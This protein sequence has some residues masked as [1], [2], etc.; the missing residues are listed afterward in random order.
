M[1]ER[2]NQLR[3]WTKDRLIVFDRDSDEAIGCVENISIE[4]LM[5]TSGQPID[6]SR[7]IR[8]RVALPQQ[9]LD[10][11]QLFFDA[12]VKW[13]READADG[14]LQ[15]GLRFTKLEDVDRKIIVKLLANCTVAAVDQVDVRALLS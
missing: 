13:C 15:I 6:V 3:G 14:M 9:H 12:K 1:E 11:D 4:G 10:R 7:F 5:V 2:R 8:C